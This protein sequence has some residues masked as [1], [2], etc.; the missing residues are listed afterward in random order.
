MSILVDQGIKFYEAELG[1]DSPEMVDYQGV[2]NLLSK[3]MESLGLRS[4]KVLLDPFSSS[5]EVARWGSL[6]DVVMGGCSQSSLNIVKS[7]GE[8]GKDAL[9]F[10]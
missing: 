10:R 6:D 2:C 4:G 9:V 7:A 5:E 3:S 8:D 1:G